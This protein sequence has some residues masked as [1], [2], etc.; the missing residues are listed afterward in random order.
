MS[1]PLCG[2]EQNSKIG[3]KNGFKLVLCGA[4]GFIH[5]DPMPGP[6]QLET[7]YDE[8]HKTEDY[9]RK[10][11]KKQLSSFI[12]LLRLKKYL[13]AGRMTFLDVG[14]SVGAT[15]QSAHRLGYQATGIDLDK[16][17]LSQAGKLFPDCEFLN[18]SSMDLAKQGRR[19][20]LIYCAEV[21]EHVPHPH[22][23]VASLSSLLKPD[24]IL[25]LTTPDAGHRTV[26]ND[27]VSWKRVSPPEQISYFTRKTMADVLT[28]H[29]LE[30]IKFL[31]SHRSA[32]RVIARKVPRS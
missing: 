21:I 6:E 29:G 30:P 4:C 19:F 16:R 25:F 15:V 11:N 1:C 28:G 9:L 10:L 26:P 18:I 32:L 23:F 3:E 13:S 17:V 5:V 7:L 12:K 20:D 24:A 31:W 14:C 2:K 8:F 22:E 27:F